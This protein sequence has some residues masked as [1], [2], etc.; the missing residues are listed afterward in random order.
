MGTRSCT[1]DLG[2]RWRIHPVFYVS[3]LEPYRASVR[4]DR[5]QEPPPPE[6]IE[7]EL[8]WTVEKIIRSELRQKRV[9]SGRGYRQEAKLYYLVKWEGYPDD[10]NTIE[11][12]DSLAQ[13]IP[14]LVE[15]FHREN[16]TIAELEAGN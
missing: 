4:D 10:E 12:A 2:N 8:E 3:L 16:P 11:P 7:G 14:E 1:L 6:E 5:C 13:D 15:R 9:R